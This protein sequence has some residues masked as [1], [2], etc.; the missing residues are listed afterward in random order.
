MSNPGDEYLWTG[1]VIDETDH[2]RLMREF[3]R[4]F[5]RRR[6]RLMWLIIVGVSIS[7]SLLVWFLMK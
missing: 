2:E 4:K 5:S 1:R 3:D 7:T 6:R